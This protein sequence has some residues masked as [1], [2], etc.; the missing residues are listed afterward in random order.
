MS[1]PKDRSDAIEQA[2]QG[3]KEWLAKLKPWPGGRP[4]N[5]SERPNER[6]SS[7][8][9]F[10]AV[11]CNEFDCVMHYTRFLKCAGV[12]WEHMHLNFGANK[13]MLN[14]PYA[15]KPDL[16]IVDPKR[17]AGAQLPVDRG[18]FLLDAVFE[19]ALVGTNQRLTKKRK[20]KVGNDVT[21][22][23]GYIRPPGPVAP[24]SSYV[25]LVEEYETQ[26]VPEAPVGVEI[27]RLRVGPPNTE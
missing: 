5:L 20:H 10:G 23:E 27:R 11:L 2:T 14:E 17:F 3:M 16:V 18:E 22:A 15:Q 6:P 21:K 1:Q 19:F 25:I 13:W 7:Q 24:G 8:A 12:P 26:N 4:R 9:Y